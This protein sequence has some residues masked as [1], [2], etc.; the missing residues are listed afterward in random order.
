MVLLLNST[1]WGIVVVIIL[2]EIII[3]IPFEVFGMLFQLL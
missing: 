2:I 3:L 1:E